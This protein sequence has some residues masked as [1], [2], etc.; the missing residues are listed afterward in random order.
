[1]ELNIN[2]KVSGGFKVEIPEEVAL[3]LASI[4]KG[5]AGET[6]AKPEEKPA[7]HEPSD[8]PFDEVTAS[9][10][11]SPE[12]KPVEEK[13]KTPRKKK[14]EEPAPE[15]TPEP[16]AAEKPSEPEEKKP[17]YTAEYIR[18]EMTKV[19][20]A[21]EYPNGEKDEDLHRKLTQLFMEIS[22]RIANVKPTAMVSLPNA[23]EVVPAFVE[24]IGN[25]ELQ[26]GEI[27]VKTPF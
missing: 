9:E 15:P 2:V 8:L 17:T 13:P 3:L 20:K 21:I 16:E 23:A 22:M 18:A 12:E 19:R 1:M 27:V 11:E 6:K 4:L 25:L 26:D 5:K 24:Y 7:D 14:K 10:L